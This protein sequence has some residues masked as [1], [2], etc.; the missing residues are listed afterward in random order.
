M[1]K[2]KEKDIILEKYKKTKTKR[3]VSF[4]ITI[5]LSIILITFVLWIGNRHKFPIFLY[6]YLIGMIICLSLLSILCFNIKWKL[7]YREKILVCLYFLEVDFDDYLTNP[8]KV[9]INIK[10]SLAL[11]KLKDIIRPPHVSGFKE[12]QIFDEFNKRLKEFA[13]YYLNPLLIKPVLGQKDEA[14]KKL[15]ILIK[16]VEDSNLEQGINFL[17]TAYKKPTPK[18][19]V[20]YHS[21]MNTL[22]TLLSSRLFRIISRIVLLLAI[23]TLLFICAHY[24]LKIDNSNSHIWAGAIFTIGILIIGSEKIKVW[25]ISRNL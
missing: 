22:K 19:K 4:G 11:D 16:N 18:Y 25:L 7:N 14:L 5:I 17:K 20:V 12:T 8:N 3:V 6:P 13:D 1:Y 15:E 23:Y 10:T 21:F 9:W 2:S 24:V